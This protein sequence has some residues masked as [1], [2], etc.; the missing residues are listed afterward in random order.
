MP[1][2]SR[3]IRGAVYVEFLLVFLPVFLL[4]LAVIQLGFIYTG[5]MVVQHAA[6][7][8]ARAAVVI[9]DD[10][11]ALYGNEPRDQVNAGGATNTPSALE[12][13]MAGAG[14]GG[15]AAPP[16]GSPRFRDIHSAAAIPLLA[17]AP[18]AAQLNDKDS[19]RRAIGIGAARAQNGAERYNAAAMAVTFPVAP[20]ATTFRTTFGKHDLITVR[21]TYLQHCS[22]P[23]VPVLMC[24]GPTGLNLEPE[25]AA[26]MDLGYLNSLTNPRFQVLRA[27]TTL[28]NQGADYLY[29]S[30][31]PP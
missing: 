1:A 30:E 29:P 16:A 7:R 14:Y 24:H 27:E 17:V 10:D 5:R 15:G 6:T 18:S 3:D 13:F 19:V 20:G 22:V 2:L 12:A 28:R 26:Q 9:L 25:E 21:V 11:P 8:A 23:L 31:T 4:F